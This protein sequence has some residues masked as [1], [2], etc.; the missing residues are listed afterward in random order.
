MPA[1]RDR[2][3]SAKKLADQA[4][5]ECVRVGCHATTLVTNIRELVFAQLFK[6]QVLDCRHGLLDLV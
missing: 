4:K 6:G 3:A 1:E 2:C 5:A